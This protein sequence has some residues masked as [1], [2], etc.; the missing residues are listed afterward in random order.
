MPIYEYECK[1]CGNRLEKL[2]KLNAEPLVDCPSCEQPD[3][4]RLVSAAG[5]RLAGGGWYE[6]DFKTGSK[7][8]L[9]ANGSSEKPA[10]EP[11]S[12][13]AAKPSDT[14]GSATPKHNGTAA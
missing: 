5:F 3:L 11:A 7:K 13:N 14:G 4:V 1:A 10:S 6:T 8:N 9:A 2:Q 12:K